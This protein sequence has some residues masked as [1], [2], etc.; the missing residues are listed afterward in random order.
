MNRLLKP[1]RLDL[2]PNSPTAAKEWNHWL[3]SLN[4]LVDGGGDRGGE[5][6]GG[7]DCS[8]VGAEQVSQVQSH[9]SDTVLHLRVWNISRTPIQSICCTCSSLLDL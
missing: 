3:S 8:N 5:A 9:F 4:C 7:G 1:D 2:D 6:V